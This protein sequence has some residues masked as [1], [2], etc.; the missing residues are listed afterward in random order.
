MNSNP[1]FATY[2]LGVAH[3]VIN[4]EQRGGNKAVGKS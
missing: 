1:S 4:K 2:A 3:Y